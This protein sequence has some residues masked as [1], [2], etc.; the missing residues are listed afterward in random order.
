MLPELANL[1]LL[2]LCTV[3]NVQADMSFSLR[4]DPQEAVAHWELSEGT[5]LVR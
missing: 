4:A 3:R 5:A 1:K 2:S